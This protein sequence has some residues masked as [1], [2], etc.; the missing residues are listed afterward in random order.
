MNSPVINLNRDDF[1]DKG[2][3]RFDDLL[4]TLYPNMPF[5]VAEDISEIDEVEFHAIGIRFNGIHIS[6]KIG[7]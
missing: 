2:V 5:E 1:S 3:M 4:H 7:T 6:N